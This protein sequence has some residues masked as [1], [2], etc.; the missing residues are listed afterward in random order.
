MKKDA[1]DHSNNDNIRGLRSIEFSSMLPDLQISAT[2]NTLVEVSIDGETVFSEQMWPGDNGIV[3]EDLR[4][5]VEPYCDARQTVELEVNGQHATVV[6]CHADFGEETAEHYLQ[7]HFLS[8]L[9][10][11]KLTAL[12]RLELLPVQGTGETATCTAIYSD[13]S[14]ATFSVDTWLEKNHFTEYDV[15]P[16][17]FMTTGKTLIGYTISV[18]SRTQEYEL[19]LSAPD[20]A[21][22]LIFE[23]SFGMEEVFYCTGLHKVAPTYKRL[24]S[25]IGRIQ[26]NYRIVETRAFH[27]DTG[28]L[29]MP[30]ANWLDDLFR[31]KYVR[32]A[33]LYDGMITPGKEILITDSKSEYSNDDAEIPRFTF[34]Y[35][36]A[37]SNHN[38]VDL[39][40]AGRIF[41][42]TFDNTFN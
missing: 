32:V 11:R 41:D 3:L 23:N 34:T 12:G 35:Q 18:G 9:Q 27:A 30:M 14:N 42:N 4:D 28:P 31:S 2:G 10:G 38:V 40:R 8:I 36:Y 1:M 16:S 24:S 20:C 26:R 15:S 5:L 22:I 25:Y 21:P 19:D 39:R 6:C 29:T 33:N 7:N 13:G 17:N 37:Q